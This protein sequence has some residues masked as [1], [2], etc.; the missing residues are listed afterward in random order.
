MPLPDSNKSAVYRSRGD[1][2]RSGAPAPGR[3]SVH[4]AVCIKEYSYLILILVST[5]LAMAVAAHEKKSNILILLSGNDDVYLDVATAITNSTIKLCRN[6]QLSCQDANFEISQIS[7]LDNKLGNNHRVI[8]TLGLNAAAYA[9]QHLNK[10]IVF[11]ALIPKVSKIYSDDGS[12]TP[13]HY[14]LYLDQPQHRSMLLINA[15]SDGFRNVGVVISSNDETAEKT[16][17]Q[18]ASELE[19]N[20]NIEKIDDANH[21]GTSLNRLLYNV[22]I[23]LA[24]PDTKIHN[25]TTVSNILIS[26]YRKRIPLI[27]FSSAYVKAGAL[28]AVYSS[29]EDVAFH[30]RDNIAKIYSGERINSREQYAEYFSILFNSEVARSLDFPTKSVNELEETMI[31][32]LIDYHD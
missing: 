14:Y 29:P 11:S 22:D 9:R 2:N 19:L 30:V 10:H 17:I 5:M 16:L 31:N 20:L 27:G 24:V 32:R 26:A 18:S 8:V 1:T 3:E 15:L 7:T 23:L 12:D 21:I 6:R 13:E 28:A 4:C 25:K